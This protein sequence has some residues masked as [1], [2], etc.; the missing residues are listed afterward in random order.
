M[1]RPY[2]VEQY[3]TVVRGVLVRREEMDPELAEELA[4]KLEGKS[5]DV[6]DA[7]R[8]GR[9]SGQLGIDKR[10]NFCWP[11]DLFFHN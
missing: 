6:R 3:R 11:S 5:Q 2:D 7:V 1:L 8:V 4:K 10:F 9:L